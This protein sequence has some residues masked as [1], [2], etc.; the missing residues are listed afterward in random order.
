MSKCGQAGAS[1]EAAKGWVWRWITLA[2]P[3]GSG[4]RSET[5]G[6][7]GAAAGDRRPDLETLTDKPDVARRRGAP[8]PLVGG[9]AT[10][11]PADAAPATALE[12]GQALYEA[13]CTM[14][15]GD[16]GQGGMGTALSAVLV[17]VD[18]LRYTRAATAQGVPGSMMPAWDA[19]SGGPLSSAELDDVAAYVVDLVRR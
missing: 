3:R 12:R 16:R 10:P 7:A 4:G 8:H 14:C 13:H 1:V 9:L 2:T 15:H 5:T 11:G 6:L 17:S 19:A 18:P